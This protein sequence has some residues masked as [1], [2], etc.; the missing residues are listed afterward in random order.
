MGTIGSV[1]IIPV[2]TSLFGFSAIFI[3]FLVA[4][5]NGH[6]PLIIPFIRRHDIWWRRTS[7]SLL[8]MGIMGAFFITSTASFSI[9]D[10][11]LVHMICASI[12]FLLVTLYIWGQV[13]LSFILSPSM[14]SPLLNLLRLL[15]CLLATI[16][17]ILRQSFI[18]PS[19]HY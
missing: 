2:L 6:V 11:L 9:T 16:S 5:Q 14:S 4:V 7:L 8:I 17:L 18:I 13:F 3:P 1:W 19:L 10:N 12:S 15:L